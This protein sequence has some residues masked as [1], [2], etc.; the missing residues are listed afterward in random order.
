MLISPTDY[1]VGNPVNIKVSLQN[2]KSNHS[3]SYLFLLEAM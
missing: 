2:L 1:P 3:G